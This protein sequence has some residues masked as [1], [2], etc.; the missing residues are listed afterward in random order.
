MEANGIAE[1]INAA[2]FTDWNVK[3]NKKKIRSKDKGTTIIKRSLAWIKFSKVPPIFGKYPVS[4]FTFD[5]IS[6][7]N[8]FTILS[9]SL[10]RTLNPTRILRFAS[11]RCIWLGP[12]LIEMFANS[13]MGISSPSSLLTNNWLKSV[14]LSL[15][16]GFN[17]T[18]SSKRF[19]PSK[20]KPEA[21][22]ANPKLTTR[23]TS[24]KE[25]L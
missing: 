25:T 5:F 17:F 16:S 8:S 24:S 14:M 21:C 13:E 6:P 9:T 4:N 23:F 2:C 22:P 11:S 19:S 7:S 20:T 12:F 3:Y 1:K 18:T 10:P 15:N